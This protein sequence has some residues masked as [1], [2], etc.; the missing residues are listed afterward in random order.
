MAHTYFWLIKKEGMKI[1]TKLV[2]AAAVAGTIIGGTIA[3]LFAPKKG[4]D[5]RRKLWKSGTKMSDDLSD[6]FLNM[7]DKF[8][9]SKEKVNEEEAVES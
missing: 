8:A 4:S 5:T 2:L 6:L 7:K 1:N 9:K 3:L